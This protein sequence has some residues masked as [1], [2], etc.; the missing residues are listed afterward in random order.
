[1]LRKPKELDA[2]DGDGSAV[3]TAQREAKAAEGRDEGR[4]GAAAGGEETDAE[5]AAA[6]GEG[7]K[8]G[9]AAAREERAPARNEG[10]AADWENK[11]YTGLA[12]PA[13]RFGPMRGAAAIRTTVTVDF[14]LD[15]C[16]DYR[17]TGF[18][19][20]GDACKFLHDRGETAGKGS[21]LLDREWE[22]TQRKKRLEEAEALAAAE[23]G[24]G[25]TPP[26][27]PS[28][29]AHA[30]VTC[31]ICKKSPPDAP[32]EARCGHVF[33]ERCALGRAAAKG[34]DACPTCGAST[35][36]SF[37]PVNPSKRRR[38]V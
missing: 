38:R 11:V 2:D 26:P 32:V 17:K 24:E 21:W 25:A 30:A 27:L 22:E 28:A 23:L 1:M 12:K 29:G 10:P 33:C 13:N 4:A 18:C 34:G 16:E 7:G 3:R 6:A 19:G 5:E 8:D 15:V 31:G 36:G 35:G 9:R 37:A 20:Y 14:A